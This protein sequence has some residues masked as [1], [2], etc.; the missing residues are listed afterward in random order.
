MPTLKQEFIYFN[1]DFGRVLPG[2]M[3]YFYQAGTTT[4]KA[5]YANKELTLANPWPLVADGAGRF[6]IAWL[7]SGAYR[8]IVKDAD[9]VQIEDRDDIN[10]DDE[11]IL[12]SSYLVF[13]TLV[14]AKLGILINGS[15]VNLEIGQAVKT[16]GKVTSSDGLGGEW[17]VVAGGTGTADDDLYSDLGNGLQL[18]RL[19]NKPRPVDVPNFYHTTVKYRRDYIASASPG[20][21]YDVDNQT[22]AAYFS[23]GPTGSGASFTWTELDQLPADA[24]TIRVLCLISMVPTTPGDGDQITV[25]ARVN[26]SSATTTGAVDLLRFTAEESTVSGGFIELAVEADIPISSQ[27]VF[28]ISWNQSGTTSPTVINLYLRGFEL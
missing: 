17:V 1:D 23:V 26:G 12:T 5:T 9:G 7:E 8:I 28:D 10:L 2:A 14:D 25:S 19:Y 4:P 24:K 16:L 22:K 6:P 15:T 27:N 3:M 13:S 21:S 18:Q 11:V 20:A